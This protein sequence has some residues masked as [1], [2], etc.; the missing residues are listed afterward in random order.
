MAMD[1][2]TT[3]FISSDYTTVSGR[4]DT[5]LVSGK[6]STERAGYRLDSS[7][8]LGSNGER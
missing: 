3:V 7:P 1:R 5:D 6:R 8:T 2:S 4:I